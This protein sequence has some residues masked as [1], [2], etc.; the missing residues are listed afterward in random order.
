[1]SYFLAAPRTPQEAW[2]VIGHAISGNRRD[3]ANCFIVFNFLRLT[4]T[5][6]EVGD[7]SSP[8]AQVDLTSPVPDAALIKYP[9][10][11]GVPTLQARIESVAAL[12]RNPGTGQL[13]PL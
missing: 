7:P 3:K 8:L 10:L 6:N 9:G 12:H 11:N 2:G 13:N 4:C 1:M 5:I